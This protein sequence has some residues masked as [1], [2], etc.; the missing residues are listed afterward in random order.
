MHPDPEDKGLLRPIRPR[1]TA[2]HGPM[3]WECGQPR[4]AEKSIP[5]L[6]QT[7]HM[8]LTYN[9]RVCI[10]PQGE[11]APALVPNSGRSADMDMGVRRCHTQPRSNNNRRCHV[12]AR[13]THRNR[14]NIIAQKRI[15]TQ[16]RPNNDATNP[17]RGPETACTTSQKRSY[18]DP[19]TARTTSQNARTTTQK[20]PALRAQIARTTGPKSP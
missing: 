20:P 3:L 15:R 16:G 9:D 14:E 5:A 8:S 17:Q 19:E 18:Y 6:S 2:N 7:V 1:S 13:N 10:Y 12:Q 4:R 11:S